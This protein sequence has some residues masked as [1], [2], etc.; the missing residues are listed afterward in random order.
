[1]T[2]SLLAMPVVDIRDGGILEAARLQIQPSLG[3]S[4]ACELSAKGNRRDVIPCCELVPPIFP[5]QD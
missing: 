2:A 4:T 5:L 1:M 3:A